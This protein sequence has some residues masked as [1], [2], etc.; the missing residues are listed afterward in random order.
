MRKEKINVHLGNEYL[1]ERFIQEIYGSPYSW[2]GGKGLLVKG[3]PGF[4]IESRKEFMKENYKTKIIIGNIDDRI[5]DKLIYLATTKGLSF[6]KELSNIEK[7]AK[8][9]KGNFLFRINRG[10]A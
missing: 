10:V 2:S 1:V 8:E 3:Y 4:D 7:M 5:R 9:I 6:L